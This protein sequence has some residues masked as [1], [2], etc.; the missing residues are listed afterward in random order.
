MLC[1]PTENIGTRNSSGRHYLSQKPQKASRPDASHHV[2]DGET[3]EVRRN[4]RY[5]RDGRVPTNGVG[6]PQGRQWTEA[7]SQFSFETLSL[8]H[9]ATM[10]LCYFAALNSPY[11]EQAFVPEMY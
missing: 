9:F 4:G 7:W 1:I 5:G 6:M 3:P 10:L 2:E 8:C 11:G